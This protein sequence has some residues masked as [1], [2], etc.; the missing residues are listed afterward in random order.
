M[1][2]QIMHEAANGAKSLILHEVEGSTPKVGDALELGGATRA[3]VVKVELA[4]TEAAPATGPDIVHVRE[5]SS[6]MSG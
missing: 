2:Y 5:R 6:A 4:G 1:P 3:D